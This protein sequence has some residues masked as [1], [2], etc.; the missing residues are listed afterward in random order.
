MKVKRTPAD[1]WFSK[2]IRELHNHTCAYCGKYCGEKHEH[3]RLDCSHIFS[4]RHKSTRWLVANAVAHCFTCHQYL[5]E[6]PI[7][8]AAWV[9][10]EF[11]QERI[12]SL[13]KE[14]NRVV[15]CNKKL[16]REIEAELKRQYEELK[17][18]GHTPLGWV[19][20]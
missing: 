12:D 16:E 1:D 15:K 2:L 5:G 9:A 20:P 18:S 11:G 14:R 8:F 13:N 10:K 3:G 6:N 17:E 7:E 4:R 19:F